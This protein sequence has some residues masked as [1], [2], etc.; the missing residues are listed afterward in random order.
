MTSLTNYVYSLSRIFYVY[1]VRD[2]AQC[3][4]RCKIF[5]VSPIILGC[6]TLR[7]NTHRVASLFY[8]Y[9]Q[10]KKKKKRFDAEDKKAAKNS[11]NSRKT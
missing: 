7:D 1:S 8:N 5:I 2:A 4:I 9:T 11:F 3:G 6:H 10:S